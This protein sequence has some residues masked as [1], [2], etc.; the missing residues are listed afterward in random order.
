MRNPRWHETWNE[1][2]RSLLSKYT[3]FDA[4][5][6]AIGYIEPVFVDVPYTVNKMIGLRPG[7]RLEAWAMSSPVPQLLDFETVDIPP[8]THYRQELRWTW[9]EEA[10]TMQKQAPGTISGGPK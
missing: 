2:Q 3:E 10:R 1:Y 6:Y 9:T 5:Y 8:E 4:D 7:Q